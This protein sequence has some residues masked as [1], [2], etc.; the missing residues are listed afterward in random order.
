ME[1]RRLRDTDDLEA[2]A[3]FAIAGMRADL[4]P[5]LRVSR[6]KVLAV[7]EHCQRSAA[8]FHLVAFDAGRI[9]AAIAAIKHE[10]LWFERCEAHVI[11]CRSVAPGA[12]FRLFAALRRWADEDM[13]VRRVVF[14]IEF[15][16]DPRQAE[17][18]ARRY[19]FKQRADALVHSKE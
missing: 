8:D 5:G 12:G 11:I 16:A 3:D 17:V 6:E 18:L 10:M 13:M 15:H 14:P 1:F 7:V 19:G 4:Y 9:V 2:V